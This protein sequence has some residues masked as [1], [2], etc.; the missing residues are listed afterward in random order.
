MTDLPPRA[1]AA[2]ERTARDLRSA[3]LAACVLVLSGVAWVWM[4]RNAVERRERVLSSVP[5]FPARGQERQ[6]RRP[7]GDSSSGSAIDEL[8]RIAPC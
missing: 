6:S 8:S 5:A 3:G 1:S 7:P 4:S 2:R